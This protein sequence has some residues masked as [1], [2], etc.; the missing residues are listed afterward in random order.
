M[1]NADGVDALKLDGAAPTI[2]GVT[3]LR[4]TRSSCIWLGIVEAKDPSPLLDCLVVVRWVQGS[5][6]AAMVDLNLWIGAGVARIHVFNHLPDVS[7]CDD[8]ETSN[9]RNTILTPA[10][11]AGVLWI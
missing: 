9:V 1:S 7:V 11:I 4:R 8:E 5:I 2:R 10:Q 3:A 6:S